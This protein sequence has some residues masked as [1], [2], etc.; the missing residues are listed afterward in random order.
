MEKF[1]EEKIHQLKDTIGPLRAQLLNH[2]VY[3]NISGVEELRIF[4]EHHIFAVWDFMSLLKSLQRDLT[5]VAT[6]W[7][8]VKNPVA[9]RLINEIVLGEE[10]DEDLHGKPASHFDLYHHAMKTMGA[11]TSKIDGLIESLKQ[12]KTLG[13]SLNGL[14]LPLSVKEFLQFTFDLI[15]SGKTHAVAAAF[16]FGR[17]DLIPDMFTSLVNDLNARVNA[18]LDEVVYYLERHIELD[19]DVHGPMA[20]E[21]ITE[22]CEDDPQ[23]WND[24]ITVSKKA[25]ETRIDL[26][27]GILEEIQKRETVLD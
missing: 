9:A 7:V 13:E 5:C 10:S 17:E 19:A 26:W 22:L 20:R 25:L 8:P 3:K 27:D 4:M 15:D 2:E 16:T 12:G 1:Q 14:H 18:N 21:M 24:V 6:P 23:K 11:D